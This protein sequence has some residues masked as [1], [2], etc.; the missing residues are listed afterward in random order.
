MTLLNINICLH[1]GC[2]YLLAIFLSIIVEKSLCI[3]L[4]CL[5]VCP[6]VCLWR[7]NSRKYSSNTLK[8]LYVIQVF[9]SIEDIEN[10]RN[11]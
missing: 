9:Y 10:G 7:F 6:S 2:I 8:L 11:L 3:P 5:S 1:I 4:I